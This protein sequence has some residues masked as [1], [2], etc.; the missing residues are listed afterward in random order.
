MAKTTVGLIYGGQSFEH[1]VS[2]MTAKS[3]LKNIDQK[4]FV[5]VNIYINKKGKFDER[6]LNNIDVALLAV[7]GP[8]GEDGKLQRYLDNKNIPYTGSGTEASRLNMDKIMMHK[9]FDKFN[10]PVVDY[11][12]F[13][14]KNNSKIYDYINKI[15]LP[16][17]IKPNNGGSSVGMTKVSNIKL[18]DKAVKR[19]YKYDK[20]IIVEKAVINPREIEIGILGNN[21]L[22]ISEPSEIIS[23]GKFYSYKAKYQKPFQ[24]T[25]QSKIDKAISKNLKDIA[26]KAYRVTKCKG[27]SRVDFLLDPNNN[28]Y[29][30]EINTLPGFTDNS[31]FPKMMAH[32]GITYKELITK[33]IELAL[34][35]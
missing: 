30:N 20:K 17:F 22:I 24:T 33:I 3:I 19:A 8:N 26:I 13:D 34:Q 35:I 23:N 31:M 25:I 28:I 10:L 12:G 1:D 21:D 6:L 27:Y 7:H 9:T 2:I 16:V 32:I 18:A 11:R 4:K 5:V 15:G 29:L 14:K